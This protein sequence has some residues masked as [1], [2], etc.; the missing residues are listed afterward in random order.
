M[1]RTGI[2]RIFNIESGKSY[3]GQSVDIDR[4]LKYHIKKL[5]DGLHFNRYLQ[6]AYSL[7]GQ[8]AF[9]FAVLEE[10]SCELLVV[11]EQYWMDFFATKGGLYNLAPA[12][13]STLGVKYS[14]ETRKKMSDRMRGKRRVFSQDHRANISLGAKNRKTQPEQTEE[15]RRRRSESM[16]ARWALKRVK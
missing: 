4:R 11:R 13:G 3:I 8:N 7:Y 14:E 10:C 5:N 16:K 1:K 15:T 9:S 12:A 6:N 2:Y